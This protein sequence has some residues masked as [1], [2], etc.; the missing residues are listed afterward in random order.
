V[1]APQTFRDGVPFP[2][3]RPDGTT[4][5]DPQVATETLYAHLPPDT[6]RELARRLRPLAPV[7]GDQ[8]AYDS[9][10]APAA[11]IYT[12]EDE[13]FEPPW[14]RRMAR[15]L[16]TE[17]IELPGGHFPMLERPSELA[18]VLDRLAASR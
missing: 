3:D 14:Q 15:E 16:D 7:A 13:I 2:P 1:D 17:P 18:R 10:A 8:P 11:L 9:S 4:V 5:W 6:A 12:T